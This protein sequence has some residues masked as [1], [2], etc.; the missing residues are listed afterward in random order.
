MC[1]HPSE[2]VHRRLPGLA[3]SR[4]SDILDIHSVA[5]RDFTEGEQI[6]SHI[7]LL[8]VGT[9]F[10]H[11]LFA[12]HFKLVRE[13]KILH[14]HLKTMMKKQI[15]SSAVRSRQQCWVTPC[16]HSLQKEL[17]GLCTACPFVSHRLQELLTSPLLPPPRHS[18]HTHAV[19]SANGT[20]LSDLPMVFSITSLAF[21][22]W[23]LLFKSLVSFTLQSLHCFIFLHRFTWDY[24]FTY[25]CVLFLF[26]LEHSRQEQVCS[27][28]TESW[29][30]HSR[31]P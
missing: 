21:L 8:Y 11:V 23:C 7:L 31:G 4:G 22:F 27:F 25:R 13:P 1:G 14:L 10:Q 6:K 26:L 5:N 28:P 9:K 19:P 3:G 15:R 17:C 18:S 12:G 30:P 16:S 2:G 24:V 29:C 20:L